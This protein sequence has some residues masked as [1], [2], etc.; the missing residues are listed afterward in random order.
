MPEDARAVDSIFTVP[1]LITLTAHIVQVLDSYNFSYHHCLKWTRS[2]TQVV[3]GASHCLALTNE[4]QVYAWGEGA[5]QVKDL[6][7]RELLMN[8]MV[9]WNR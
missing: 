1:R 3:S 8:I 4:G 5:N 9:G 2:L 7:N 6:L